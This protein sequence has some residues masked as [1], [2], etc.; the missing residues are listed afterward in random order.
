MLAS[1]AVDAKKH[2]GEVVARKCPGEH[3]SSRRVSMNRREVV[4]CRKCMRLKGA[5]FAHR[6]RRSI[7]NRRAQPWLLARRCHRES[8]VGT[9][10][11]SGRQVLCAPRRPAAY[12]ILS[13]RLHPQSSSASSGSTGHST[14][15]VSLS[16]SSSSTRSQS[17]LIYPSN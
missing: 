2:G 12:V 10:K 6:L 3:A 16:T 7:A 13:G 11:T 9:E 15:C 17:R 5:I 14:Y 1:V 4:S 8:G